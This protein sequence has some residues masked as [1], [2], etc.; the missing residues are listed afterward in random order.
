MSAVAHIRRASNHRIRIAGNALIAAAAPMRMPAAAAAPAVSCQV[1][2]AINA[3]SS[4]FMFWC[5]KFVCSGSSTAKIGANRS[6]NG[7]AEETAPG[8]GTVTGD[9][10]E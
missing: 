10:P 5:S 2:P 7:G 3:N 6:G 4:A 1:A 9:C 8:A